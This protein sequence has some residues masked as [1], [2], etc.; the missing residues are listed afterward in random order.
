MAKLTL[1]TGARKTTLSS[2]NVRAAISVAMVTM[3]YQEFSLPEVK[4]LH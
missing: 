3:Q 4:K 1:K 2:K